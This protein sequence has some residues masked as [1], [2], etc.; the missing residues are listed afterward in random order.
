M[1][2]RIDEQCYAL[3][4]VYQT[5]PTTVMSCILAVQIV[6][7]SGSRVQLLL[8][9]R[10]G[11]WMKSPSRIGLNAND[12]TSSYYTEAFAETRGAQ[13]GHLADGISQSACT[14]CL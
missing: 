14:A 13:D 1:Q 3:N 10:F 6:W 5:W 9:A 11:S 8:R 12:G 2:T 7:T 4:Y